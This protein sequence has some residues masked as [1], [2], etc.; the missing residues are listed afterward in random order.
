MEKEENKSWQK[1]KKKNYTHMP[2]YIRNINPK[3]AE[4]RNKKLFEGKF[5]F[6][7]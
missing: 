6:Q 1:R 4:E 5:L 3:G 2:A 7:F